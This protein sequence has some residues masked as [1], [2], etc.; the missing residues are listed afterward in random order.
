MKV[1][2]V[3]E[4]FRKIAAGERRHGSFLTTFS[5]AM[6]LADDENE[7]ILQPVAHSLIEKYSLHSYALPEA[8]LT[9]TAREKER[10]EINE[11]LAAQ[12][13][14]GLEAESQ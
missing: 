9:A 2:D 7:L 13:S 3:R 10:R 8:E 14:P 6:L 4:V 11:A 12:G 5:Q 1:S